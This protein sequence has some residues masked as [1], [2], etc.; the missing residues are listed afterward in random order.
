MSNCCDT[1][2]AEVSTI[3][4]ALKLATEEVFHDILVEG[5]GK[6]CFDAIQEE[7]FVPWSFFFFLQCYIIYIYILNVQSIL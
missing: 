2:P 4:W 5:D 7:N 6:I 1:L 3:F